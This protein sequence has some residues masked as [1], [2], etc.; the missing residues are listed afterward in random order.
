MTAKQR[1]LLRSFAPFLLLLAGVVLF[2]RLRYPARPVAPDPVVTVTAATTVAAALPG[3]TAV[4]LHAG[5][6]D[7]AEPTA[8]PLPPL[9]DGE[10]VRLVGPPPD[11]ALPLETIVSFYWTSAYAPADEEMYAVYL[12]GEGTEILAGNI[13]ESNLGQGYQLQFDPG[14][15]SLSPGPYLWE[16]RLVTENLPEAR[17]R[18]AQRAVTF[19]PGRTPAEGRTARPLPGL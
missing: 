15:A 14:S 8:V 2:N 3:S 16:V 5:S 19:Q 17:W 4:P 6:I 18:S 11:A 10:L 13:A 7:T 9:P 1:R 12:L